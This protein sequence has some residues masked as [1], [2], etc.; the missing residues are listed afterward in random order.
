[1]GLGTGFLGAALAACGGSSSS[2][3]SGT[4]KAAGGGAAKSGSVPTGVE[5]VVGK[6]D[7]QVWA[8]FTSNIATNHMFQGLVRLNFATN[9][10]EPCLA[11]SWE[12]PDPK[13]WIYHLREGVRS[14]TGPR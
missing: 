5:S 8:G 3:G 11:T 7:P 2:S 10:I 6:F 12:Q 4:T 14:T 1:M 13:T 9:A